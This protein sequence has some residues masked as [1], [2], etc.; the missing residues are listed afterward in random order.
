MKIVVSLI[1]AGFK[2]RKTINILASHYSLALYFFPWWKKYQKNQEN[3]D[4]QP[5]LSLRS[6]EQA[7]QVL[8]KLEKGFLKD[9]VEAMPEPKP[10]YPTI[11]T[12][13]R[14]MVQKGFTG[15]NTYGKTREY[16]PLKKCWSKQAIRWK[17]AIWL[18]M[19]EIQA[20]LPKAIYTTRLGWRASPLTL[21]SSWVGNK[22]FQSILSYGLVFMII[23]LFLHRVSTPCF[24]KLLGKSGEQ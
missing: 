24:I 3:L 1:V 18:A 10:A 13:I 19:W 14:V 12:V 16:Y 15:Y 22:E 11:S 5:A 9:I 6:D 17:R 7:M 4:Q 8:W 21:F 23:T 20:S 2:I